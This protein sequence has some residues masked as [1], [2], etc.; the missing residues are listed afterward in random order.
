VYSLNE[1]SAGGAFKSAITKKT[2]AF[3]RTRD[4][5][6][7]RRAYNE[8]LADHRQI[9]SD[10]TM[11]LGRKP[12]PRELVSGVT[13]T[14]SRPLRQRIAED[15]QL[16]TQSRD[17]SVNPYT[18]RIDQLHQQTCLTAAER[19]QRD[20]RIT[21]LGKASDDWES[22]RESERVAAAAAKRI[23]SDLLDAQTNLNLARYGVGYTGED[24]RICESLLDALKQTGDIPAYRKAR[25]AWEASIKQR[26]KDTAQQLEDQAAEQRR[27]AAL[28]RSG[29]AQGDASETP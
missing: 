12:T 3:Q 24:V 16:Q 9:E 15:G 21:R 2:Y 22:E 4:S 27:Q 11:R 7:K 18:S 19:S 20:Q 26:R 17:T 6:D 29:E 1:N 28:I 10:L 25:D 14:D 8:M 5:S 13:P 23:E